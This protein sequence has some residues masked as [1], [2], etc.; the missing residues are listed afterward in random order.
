[1]PDKLVELA[2]NPEYSELILAALIAIISFLGTRAIKAQDDKIKRNREEIDQ[3]R[4]E[5]D[6]EI[7]QVVDSVKVLTD[8]LSAQ[9]IKTAEDFGDVKEQLGVIIGMMKVL[10]KD[11]V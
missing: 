11:K 4:T 8:A 1:M 5:H 9:S 6:A 10:T 2:S 3:L 7:R